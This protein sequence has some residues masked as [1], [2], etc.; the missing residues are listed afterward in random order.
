VIKKL[1]TCKNCQV[2]GEVIP[3]KGFWCSNCGTD[4]EIIRN[5]SSQRELLLVGAMKAMFVALLCLG[6]VYLTM[7]PQLALA[8]T[9]FWFQAAYLGG[10]AGEMTLVALL[11]QLHRERMP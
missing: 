5:G 11:A 2:T 8:E 3:Q 6:F 9:P 10:I 1:K 7:F 4:E